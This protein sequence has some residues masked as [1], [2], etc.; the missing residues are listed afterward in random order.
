MS[1]LEEIKNKN[2]NAQNRSKNF[3]PFTMDV[4]ENGYCNYNKIE[5]NSL[6]ACC[7]QPL[8]LFSYN[9][10]YIASMLQIC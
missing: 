1:M 8:N 9:F 3:L 2:R 4:I 7:S 10:H 5:Q 6:V